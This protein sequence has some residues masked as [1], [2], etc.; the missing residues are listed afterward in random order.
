MPESGDKP[1]GEGGMEDI[2]E[3]VRHLKDFPSYDSSLLDG[4]QFRQKLHTWA[5]KTEKVSSLVAHWSRCILT[6]RHS[7]AVWL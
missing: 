2:P 1:A 5:S 4:P 6:H 7:P 3:D